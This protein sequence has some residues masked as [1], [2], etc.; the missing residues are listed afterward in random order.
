M[1]SFPE[2]WVNEQPGGD[3]EDAAGLE[4]VGQELAL[5]EEDE[6]E[7]DEGDEELE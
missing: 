1:S 6:L 5:D 4:G 7:L 3:E 2:E